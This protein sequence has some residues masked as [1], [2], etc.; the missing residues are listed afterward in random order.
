VNPPKIPS[1]MNTTTVEPHSSFQVGQVHFRN[2][3][4]VS[5]T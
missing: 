1:E 3:S 2:S 5:A 4:R